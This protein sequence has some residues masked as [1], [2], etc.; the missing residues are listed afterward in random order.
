MPQSYEAKETLR[1][2]Q[3]TQKKV[4]PSESVEIHW[5]VIL[6]SF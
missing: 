4:E 2:E 3:T 5:S 1:Q 6:E